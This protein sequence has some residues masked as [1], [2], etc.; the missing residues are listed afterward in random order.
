LVEACRIGAVAGDTAEEG[1][2]AD[3]AA[4]AEEEGGVAAGQET[5]TV[6]ASEGRNVSSRFLG[7]VI[8]MFAS[9]VPAQAQR[10]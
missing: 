2:D 3:T 9:N 6:L 8:S 1:G 5:W 7:A 10:I 4:A